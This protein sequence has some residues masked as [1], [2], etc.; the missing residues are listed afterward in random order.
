MDGPN[1]NLKLLEKINEERISNEFHC[2]ISIGNCGLDTIHATFRAGAEVTDWSIEK[3][4]T[5]A[6]YVLH[7]SPARREAYQEVTGS[8]KFPLSFCSTR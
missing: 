4:L 1:V 7:G 2:L 6:N 5:G 3:T 8:N